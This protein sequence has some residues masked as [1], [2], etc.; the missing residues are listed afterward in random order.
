MNKKFLIA[1]ITSFFIATIYAQNNVN[2][3]G[4]LKTLWG[5]G[6]PW[7]DRDTAAGKFLLG[8]TSFTGTLDAYY[9]KSSALAE[10]SVSYD[11]VTNTFGWS[12][13]ELWLDYTSSFWG[14]RIGRQKTAGVKQTV[15]IFL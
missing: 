12:L 8:D 4:N 1:S 7:T 2:F 10:G 14:I 5:A 9:N 3:S 11:A 6:A 15:L 13:D